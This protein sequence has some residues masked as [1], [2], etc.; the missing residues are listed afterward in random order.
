LYHL[1]RFIVAIYIYSVA[2]TELTVHSL[3]EKAQLHEQI[4]IL[5]AQLEAALKNLEVQTADNGQ[6]SRWSVIEILSSGLSK[7]TMH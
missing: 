5:N 3:E 1:V 7:V 4:E 6:L 2:S